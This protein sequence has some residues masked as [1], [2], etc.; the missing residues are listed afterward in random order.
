MT[1]HFYER[2]A[3][4][5][6]GWE[7]SKKVGKPKNTQEAT[8]YSSSTLTLW[9]PAYDIFVPRFRPKK[10]QFSVALPTP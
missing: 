9:E 4:F 3:S 7:P 10:Q 8:V 5:K 1:I 6:K 2:G